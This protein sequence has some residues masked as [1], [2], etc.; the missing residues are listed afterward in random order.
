MEKRSAERH[1]LK[2]YAA[3]TCSPLPV[4][5]MSAPETV[6]RLFWINYEK[7]G[8][9]SDSSG[10]LHRKPLAELHTAR[11][12]YPEILYQGSPVFS[13]DSRRQESLPAVR[14]HPAGAEKSSEKRIFAVLKAGSS[15]G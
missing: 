4:A 12:P 1:S 15:A 7:F 5:K 13:P 8:G 9:L 10:R 6:Y 2:V 14:G 11:G 3:S